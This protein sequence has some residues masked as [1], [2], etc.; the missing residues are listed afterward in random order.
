MF[1]IPTIKSL[2]LVTFQLPLSR[3]TVSHNHIAGSQKGFRGYGKRLL[4]Q[5]S[6]RLEPEAM[7]DMFS[8]VHVSMQEL[9]DIQT[10]SGDG[11]ILIGFRRSSW[12]CLT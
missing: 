4:T 8:Y 9:K 10:E 5:S 12:L 3:Q 2:L 11:N 7:L 1:T 6:D